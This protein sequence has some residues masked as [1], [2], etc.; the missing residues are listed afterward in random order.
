MF[1][2]KGSPRTRWCFRGVADKQTKLLIYS[3]SLH[4]EELPVIQLQQSNRSRKIKN[5]QFFK[6][7]KTKDFIYR[8]RFDARIHTAVDVLTQG[9]FVQFVRQ[10]YGVLDSV[11]HHIGP[12]VL[13]WDMDCVSLQPFHCCDLHFC[14]ASTC[15]LEF[16]SLHSFCVTFP[17]TSR[18]PKKHW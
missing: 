10:R 5:K 7:L 12:G 17:L 2:N 1:L 11:T 16:M 14:S 8:W 3:W 18:T 15:A 4:C 9:T 6:N 13:H